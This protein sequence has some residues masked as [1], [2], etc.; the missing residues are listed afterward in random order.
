MR[1]NG[2]IQRKIAHQFLWPAVFLLQ[3]LQPLLTSLISSLT[4]KV[5]PIMGCSISSLY[6]SIWNTHPWEVQ[7]NQVIVFSVQKVEGN[8][9]KI[10]RFGLFRRRPARL[11]KPPVQSRCILFRKF[12]DQP[13]P[14]DFRRLFDHVTGSFTSGSNQFKPEFRWPAQTL[15]L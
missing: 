2:I 7:C 13:L 6:R 9:A 1:Q 11:L 14:P 3:F 15:E 5:H 12:L 8:P 10:P 4:R